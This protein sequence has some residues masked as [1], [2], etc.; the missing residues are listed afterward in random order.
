MNVEELEEIPVHRNGRIGHQ[1]IRTGHV[2]STWQPSGYRKQSWSD[3]LLIT[4]LMLGLG[5]SASVVVVA[6]GFLA[7]VGWRIAE[8]FLK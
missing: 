4:A 8:G 5:V 7:Y 2:V 6:L 1:A 3:R